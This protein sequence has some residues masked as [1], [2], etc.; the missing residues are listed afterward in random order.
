M[1]IKI[2]FLSCFLLVAFVQ[3]QFDSTIQVQLGGKNYTMPELLSEYIQIPSVSG[4]ER[5]AGEFLT[6]VAREN[7]LHVTHMGQSNSNYNL[8]ASIYPLTAGLPNIILLNHIDVVPVGDTTVWEYPPFSGFISDTEI[9]GRG[10]FDNKGIGIIHLF[11]VIEM[12][13]RSV[14]CQLPY[15][16]TFLAGS[17]EETQCGGGASFVAENYLDL[18]QPAVV[19]GEGPPALQGILKSQPD[20][21]IFGIS[22]AH[23]RALWLR[24]DLIVE[25]TRHGSV[26]PLCYANQEMVEALSKLVQHR[27]KAIYTDLNTDVLRQ[28]GSLE[29]GVLRTVLKHPRLFRIVLVPQLRKQPELFALFTNTIT[30]TNVQSQTE[31]I[32]AIPSCVSAWLDCR[33]LPEA[34]QDQFLRDLRK[35][36][37]NDAI[38]IQVITDMPPLPPSELDNP[39]FEHMSAAI[40]THF[41][42]AEVASLMVPYINDVGAFRSRGVPAYSVIPTAIDRSYLDHIHGENERIPKY[43]LWEGLKVFVDFL[44]RCVVEDLSTIKVVP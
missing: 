33:L 27:P 17:C 1:R 16:I 2:L 29:K 5:E 42:D 31:S 21:W 34:D 28:L 13:R 37:D 15:N 26:T 41:P 35:I 4:W 19:I 30:L 14:G 8:A 40:L 44:E 18:L 38:T 7:G 11:S 6:R 39:F 43:M 24:L 32:N 36:L 20:T 23:K 25:S 3:A 9:W 22:V 12:A 10:A